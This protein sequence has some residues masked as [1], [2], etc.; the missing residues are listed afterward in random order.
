VLVQRGGLI[1]AALQ[2]LQAG[3][4]RSKRY[5]GMKDLVAALRARDAASAPSLN[6]QERAA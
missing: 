6:N 3:F 1:G 5:R 4:H 2:E